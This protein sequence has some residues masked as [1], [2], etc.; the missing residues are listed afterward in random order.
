MSRNLLAIASLVSVAV[1]SAIAPPVARADTIPS[2][3]F[4]NWSIDTNCVEVDDAN[5]ADHAATGLK[6]RIQAASANENNTYA[7]EM[8]TDG[9]S[10]WTIPW[11]DL[12][13]IYRP[14]TQMTSVPADFACVPGATPTSPLLAMSNYQQTPEPQFEYEHWYG[15][16]NING[17]PH[18]VLI[19]PRAASGSSNVVIVL[20]AA[21]ADSVQLDTGGT[22]HGHGY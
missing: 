17:E 19:F 18:H 11:T 20:E 2:Y 5:S 9:T 22:I 14:G 21:T 15:L 3:F 13:L 1:A 10:T 4:N 8:I 6:F 12:R 16:V 7:F